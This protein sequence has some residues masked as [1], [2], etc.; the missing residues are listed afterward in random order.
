[1]NTQLLFKKKLLVLTKENSFFT[2]R[3]SF[4]ST[5]RKPS[6]LE[7][8]FETFFNTI[9]AAPHSHTTIFS[10]FSLGSSWRH[11]PIIVLNI[12]FQMEHKE[13]VIQTIHMQ[14]AENT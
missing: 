6:K 3:K 1:M 2:P 13:K 10:H 8:K 11:N 7:Q 5:P 12:L 4:P 9:I 14:P